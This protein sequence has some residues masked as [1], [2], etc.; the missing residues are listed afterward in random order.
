MSDYILKAVLLF[1]GRGDRS[2]Q[3]MVAVWI[4][5]QMILRHLNAF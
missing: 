1:S 5:K 3:E 2:E 4:L